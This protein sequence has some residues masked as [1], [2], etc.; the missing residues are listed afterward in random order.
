MAQ[1]YAAGGP[2]SSPVLAGPDR[3]L[4]QLA[5]WRQPKG[6]SLFSS[7]SACPRAAY[8]DNPRSHVGVGALPAARP[9]RRPR[10]RNRTNFFED[11]DE[12]ENEENEKE[13]ARTSRLLGIGREPEADVAG[14]RIVR[15]EV[16]HFQVMLPRLRGIA[17]GLRAEIG[18][19]QMRAD[20]VG[21][22]REN[23]LELIRRV[24]HVARR[25][26]RE[27]EIVTGI[28]R[29]GLEGEGEFVAGQGEG[30]IAQPVREHAGVVFRLEPPGVQLRRSL[31]P[32]LG[33]GPL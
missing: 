17:Q 4:S 8:W 16:Q 24:H 20:F 33:V 7:A 26:E 9:R 10:P 23:F 6:A 12:D 19:R 1:R 13:W 2:E 25:L 31:I 21:T 28:H 30:I 11:E 29:V 32:L 3:E 15:L 5:A 22:A 18:Q 14:L 27:G